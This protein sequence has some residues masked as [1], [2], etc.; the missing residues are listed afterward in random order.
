MSWQ[1]WFVQLSGWPVFLALV[2]AVAVFMLVVSVVLTWLG[3]RSVLQSISIAALA[4]LLLCLGILIA[5]TV[6][7]R[8]NVRA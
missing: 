8:L 1:V 5:L 3:N 2:A 7:S 4:V 6:L